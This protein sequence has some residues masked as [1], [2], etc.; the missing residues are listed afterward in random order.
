MLP[1][2]FG[3]AHYYYEWGYIMNTILLALPLRHMFFDV[4]EFELMFYMN[5][6]LTPNTTEAWLCTGTY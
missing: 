5:H 4:P 1:P 2:E 3:G 6:R